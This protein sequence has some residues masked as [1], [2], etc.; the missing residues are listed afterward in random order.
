MYI[1]GLF[2][3]SK[4]FIHKII[5]LCNLPENALVV[6]FSLSTFLHFFQIISAMSTSTTGVEVLGP[7]VQSIWQQLFKHCECSEE[8]ATFDCIF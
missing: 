3:N 7:Y 5:E 8:G 6:Q 2:C 1:C 4:I